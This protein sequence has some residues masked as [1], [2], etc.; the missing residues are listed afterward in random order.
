MERILDHSG[1]LKKRSTLDFLVRWAGLDETSDLWLPYSEVRDVEATHA[2]LREHDLQRLIPK[3]FNEPVQR[4]RRSIA[5]PIAVPEGN[6]NQKRAA[7]TRNQS[8]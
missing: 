7:R 4:K 3:K 6:G 1:D 2:Y 5:Q 8:R